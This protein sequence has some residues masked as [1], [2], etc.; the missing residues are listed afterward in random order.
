VGIGQ[1]L[2]NIS[3]EGVR[4]HIDNFPWFIRENQETQFLAHS[5]K[6]IDPFPELWHQLVADGWVEKV[7]KSTRPFS[8]SQVG[9][10]A[11]PEKLQKL[12][13]FA[14]ESRTAGDIVS[15]AIPCSIDLLLR[16]YQPLID[17]RS[18]SSCPQRYPPN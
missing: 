16:E 18:A 2:V 5:S 3:F 4:Q 12:E 15:K 9:K 7:K 14:D 6:L 13:N 1:P 17:A 10:R 8:L 11:I